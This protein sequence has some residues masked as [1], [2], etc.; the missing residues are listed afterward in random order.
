MEPDIAPQ[1]SFKDLELY[2]DGFSEENFIGNF[3]FGRVYR[4][5]IPHGVNGMETQEVTVK[6]Y[7]SSYYKVPDPAEGVGRVTVEA[8]AFSMLPHCSHPNLV[9]LIGF[10]RERGQA[11]AVYDLKSQD[12]VGNLLPQ[13]DGFTWAQRIKVAL[14]IASLLEYLH[15]PEG[16]SGPCLICNVNAAHIMLDKDYNARYYD[17]STICGGKSGF[18]PRDFVKEFIGCYGY[19]DPYFA[20][21]GGAW[22]EKVDVFA[23]GVVLLGLITKR[24][25]YDPKKTKRSDESCVYKWA[26]KE[27]RGKKKSIMWRFGK[28]KS[29]RSLVNESFEG[30][31][32]FYPGDGPK[33]TKLAMRCVNYSPLKRPTMEEVV[34]RLL[35][36]DI[37]YHH[38]KEI[39]GDVPLV[40]GY[41]PDLY[42]PALSEVVSDAMWTLQNRVSEC[43]SKTRRFISKNRNDDLY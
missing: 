3:Q 34:D 5:K 20:S 25:I 42:E 40:R 24:V 38:E 2:T 9:N 18:M 29:K 10:C 1:L 21:V 15:F 31:P 33:I 39:L 37:I 16:S 32:K 22:S 13:G 19:V 11:G 4:G 12:T 30:E 41:H 26:H 35:D 6:I 8:I 17:F 7:D 28:S 36:L 43:L 14:Q 27:Y 23:F